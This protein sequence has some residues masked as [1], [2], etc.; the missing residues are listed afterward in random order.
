MADPIPRH[1]DPTPE[2][3]AL[4]RSVVAD[5]IERYLAS[6]RTRIKPFVDRHFTLAGSL[7]THRYAVGLDML[8][9]P[10]N[11]G[12]GV[13]TALKSVTAAGLRMAGAKQAGRALARRNLFLQTRVGKELEWLVYTDLLEL[14]YQQDSRV[15]ERDA[16]L[17]TILSDPRVEARVKEMLAAVGEHLDESDFRARLQASMTEYVGSRAAAAD[18]TSSL[19]AA[20]TGFV[21]Y[22]KFTPGVAALSGTVAGSIAQTMAVSNFWAGAWLGGIYYSM[23]GVQTPLWLYAGV[24]GGIMVPL[25]AMMAF[26]GV[27][28][29]PVQRRLGI[30][31]RRLK[32]LVD[33]MEKNLSGDGEATIVIRDHYAARVLDM[34]DW[35]SM[36]WRLAQR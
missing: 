22:H 4:V 35:V 19:I 31:E 34:L 6:R 5:S 16:L 20:A 33:A 9:A 12:A 27:V 28:A 10:Y 18:I 32:R 15:F 24:F 29:D 26:A 2:D 3:Q 14:P 36:V 8:R 13:A 11:V 23:V 21:A 17:E 7:K 1:Q 25:A 30:H